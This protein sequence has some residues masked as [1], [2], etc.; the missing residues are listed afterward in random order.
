MSQGRLN[1]CKKVIDH[2]FDYLKLWYLEQSEQFEQYGVRLVP[3]LGD[4]VVKY[5][6]G[7]DYELC[8][9]GAFPNRFCS[10]CKIKICTHHDHVW[11]CMPCDIHLC[12]SCFHGKNSHHSHTSWAYCDYEI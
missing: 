9:N 8:K 12:K 10:E 1:V 4:L 2:N 3:E 11:K 6:I 7:I 5:I